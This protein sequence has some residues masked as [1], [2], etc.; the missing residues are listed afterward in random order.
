M[1][2]TVPWACHT[3]GQ[4]THWLPTF[5]GTLLFILRTTVICQ[6][7]RSG[8]IVF[9]LSGSFANIP[10]IEHDR[11]CLAEQTLISSCKSQLR[12]EL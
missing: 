2:I 11:E 10:F 7:R 3:Q 9:S 12:L 6:E 5:L 8:N 4:L 1:S